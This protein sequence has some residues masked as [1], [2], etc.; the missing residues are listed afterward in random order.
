MALRSVNDA[1]V[2]NK[3]VVMRVDFNVPLNK[4]T[5][6]ITDDSRIRASLPT[7]HLL[8]DRGASIVL[9]S[10]LGRPKGQ[11]V[12]SMRLEPVANHLEE[13]LGRPVTYVRDVVGEEA[14]DVTASMEP[15]TVVLLD[16]L[17]FD[18]R[19]EQ[20]DH[21]FA[22]KLASFGD[23]YVDDAFGAAHRAHASTEAVARMLPSYAG[24]LMEA[25]IEALS[26][27][28]ENPD[29]PFM[30]V[31][32]GA[33]VSD[34]IGVIERLLQIVDG[35]A[36]GGGMANTF[37]LA[38]GLEVGE[39]LAEPDQAETAR[40][41]IQQAEENGI[42]L[43]MPIDVKVAPSLDDRAQVVDV[44]AIPSEMAVFDVGPK[45]VEQYGDRLAAARTIFWN[46]PMGVFE[47]PEFAKGTLGVAEA[48]A[49]SPAFSVVGGGD[50]LAAIEA[51]GVSDQISHL[52]TGGGASLEFLEGK[53]LPGVAVL[54][55]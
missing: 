55:D 31:L 35:I 50:S 48:V 7:I 11:V 1:D 25:E 26:K 37:L 32:G 5:G 21:D 42:A 33:K 51:A 28:L 15:G 54:T 24:L 14:S 29:R 13:L 10:H 40:R 22:A 12:E 41:L 39:S 49:V 34:K 44:D 18:A 4:S 16:N 30:A 23:V 9:M 38:R 17:R 43:L 6:V 20:N 3:R 47:K 45:T 36:L 52:S 46:G 53:V 19:E 27:V 2:A 8:L